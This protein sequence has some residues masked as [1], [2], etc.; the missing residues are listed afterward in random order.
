MHHLMSIADLGVLK[1]FSKTVLFSFGKKQFGF[2]DLYFLRKAFL[3]FTASSSDVICSP[4]KFD[5]ASIFFGQFFD[6][7]E[8]YFLR[9][10]TL[11]MKRKMSHGILFLALM[12]SLRNSEVNELF[13]T[14]L[15]MISM[16]KIDEKFFSQ[17]FKLFRAFMANF[18]VTFCLVFFTDSSPFPARVQGSINV[19][20]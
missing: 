12:L 1:I 5:S 16:I 3:A 20:F 11:K 7:D 8:I 4:S 14:T 10:Q 13:L 9:S 15:K 6:R 18:L 19:S 2:S 17:K